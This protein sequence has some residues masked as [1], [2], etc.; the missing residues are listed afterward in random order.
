[1]IAEQSFRLCPSEIVPKKSATLARV[2]T[3]LFFAMLDVPDS[4]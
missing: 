2:S 4:V 3:V 1:M